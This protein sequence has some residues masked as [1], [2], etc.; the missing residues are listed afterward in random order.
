[1]LTLEQKVTSLEL[2][3][4]MKELGFPQK[5]LFYWSFYDGGYSKDNPGIVF[6]DDC[7]FGFEEDLYS[8]YLTD[9]L[10]ELLG[11]KFESLNK[12]EENCRSGKSKNKLGGFESI[13]TNPFEYEWED[14]P[15]NALA[16]LAI[17]LKKEGVL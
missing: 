12:I 6:V 14:T 8:A 15:P 1:M 3:Q 11:D 4:Q 7:N 5:S 9:E 13:S 16:K 17:Y 10:I 2:S